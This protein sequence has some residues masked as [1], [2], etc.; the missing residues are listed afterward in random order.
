MLLVA[1]VLLGSLAAPAAGGAAD[2]GRPAIGHVF[3][4]NLENQSFH[5]GMGKALARSLS[6]PDAR[7]GKARSS[8]GTTRSAT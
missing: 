4:I 1:V 6:R 5:A 3:V 7:G 8:A 2:A